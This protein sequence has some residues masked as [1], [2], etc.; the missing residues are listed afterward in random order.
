MTEIFKLSTT[1]RNKNLGTN[2]STALGFFLNDNF[3][4]F[5]C[6]WFGTITKGNCK[7]FSLMWSMCQKNNNPQMSRFQ[8]SSRETGFN[9]Y[10]FILH[11]LL[12]KWQLVTKSETFMIFKINYS[13]YQDEHKEVF[14][15]SIR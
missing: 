6:F 10:W 8:V 2:I 11:V 3:S 13:T 4:H 12:L 5:K 15:K 7:M 9:Q 1:C 14:G